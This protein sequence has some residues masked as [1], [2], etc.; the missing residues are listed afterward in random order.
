MKVFVKAIGEKIFRK[1]G[2]FAGLGYESVEKH[3]IS[4]I[5]EIRDNTRR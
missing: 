2:R 1:G 5:D 4:S 3:V